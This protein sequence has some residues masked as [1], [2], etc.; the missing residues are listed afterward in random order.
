MI[1]ETRLPMPTGRIAVP[2]IKCQG[3]KTKLVPFIL[4]NVRWEEGARGRWIEP[5]LGSGVVAFNVRPHRA[6]LCDKNVHIVDFYSA[7]QRG[8][9][10]PVTV[11]THLEQE[12][13]ILAERG[14]DY[15]YEVRERFNQTG[16]SLDFLFL[17]RACFNGVMRFNSKGKFN[18]PWNRK[19]ERFSPAYISKIVNQV[20]AVAR[21]MHGRQ[22]KFHCCDWRV[23]LADAGREDFVYMD[24]PYVGRHVDYHGKWDDKDERDLA[25]TVRNLPSGFAVSMWKENRYRKNVYL[26]EVWNGLPVLEFEHFYHVGASEHLRNSIIEALVISPSSVA[27]ISH[28]EQPSLV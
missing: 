16:N 8:V 10:N 20:A 26:T 3:I 24:P 17:S 28:M 23:T 22:W 27:E 4:G 19:P 9:V 21:I 6:L 15:Y 11:R 1:A 2:P 5:F 25:R 12:G 7:L 18:V 13:A 14:E